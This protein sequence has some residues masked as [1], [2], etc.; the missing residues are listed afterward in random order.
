MSRYRETFP[1]RHVVLPVIP[2]ESQE[3]ALRNAEIAR[4]QGCNGVFLINHAIPYTKLLKIHRQVSEAFPDWW[5]GAN[6][7][8]L[9][10]G[11]VFVEITDRVAG[12]WVD[13]A[14]IDERV[15]HQSMAEEDH[16]SAGPEW[17]ARVVLWWRGFQIPAA[18]G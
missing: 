13:N 11:E 2:V 7:L 1:D 16:G 5:I 15:E 18:R 12:V 3:Q 8:D 4:E 17:M 9:G 6:C 10:P 14:M